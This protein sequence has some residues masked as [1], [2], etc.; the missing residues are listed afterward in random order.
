ML[1]IDKE[2]SEPKSLIERQIKEAAPRPAPDA[3]APQTPVA[4][5]DRDEP[6][7]GAGDAAAVLMAVDEDDEAGEEA[8]IPEAFDYYTDAEDGD[9]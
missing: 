4:N 7:R 9:E 3:A 5:T 2:P 1:V 6:Q 8:Q